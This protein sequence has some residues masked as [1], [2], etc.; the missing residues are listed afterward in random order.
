[1]QICEISDSVERNTQLYKHNQ[2]LQYTPLGLVCSDR[3]KNVAKAI[4]LR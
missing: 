2:N 4:F 3:F 1:M